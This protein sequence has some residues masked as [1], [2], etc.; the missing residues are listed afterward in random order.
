MILDQIKKLAKLV[1]NLRANAL[2]Q[3]RASQ[4]APEAI[5]T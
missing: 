1:T 4:Y 2:G 5:G 3:R